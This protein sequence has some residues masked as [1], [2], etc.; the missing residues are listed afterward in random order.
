MP[1]GIDVKYGK[2]QKGTFLADREACNR[3]DTDPALSD[4]FF[5]TEL[6]SCV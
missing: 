2:I 5:S 3:G 6:S 4:I 1:I